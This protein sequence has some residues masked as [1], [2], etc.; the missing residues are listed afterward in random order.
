MRGRIKKYEKKCLK[1]L[2]LK[3]PKVEEKK[4]YELRFFYENQKI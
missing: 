2:K 3:V 1:Y 4:Y